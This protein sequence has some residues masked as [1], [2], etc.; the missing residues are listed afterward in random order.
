MWPN[1]PSEI[2]GL[3]LAI[4]KFLDTPV[5]QRSGGNKRNIFIDNIEIP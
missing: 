4:M 2:L 1:N 3:D 5:L